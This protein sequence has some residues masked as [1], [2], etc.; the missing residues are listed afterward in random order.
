[1][2]R[3]RKQP[4]RQATLRIRA[5]TASAYGY[6]AVPSAKPNTG[7]DREWLSPQEQT[8]MPVHST[9]PCDTTAHTTQRRPGHNLCRGAFL[10]FQPI[11][12]SPNARATLRDTG[13]Q[14]PRF[15][16]PASLLISLPFSFLQS[17]VISKAL[18]LYLTAMALRCDLTNSRPVSNS[19]LQLQYTSIRT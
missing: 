6:A 15:N 9:T 2:G 7:R 1:M 4:R 12:P 13:N 19:G 14:S 8:G 5:H 10:T 18:R 11:I 16:G 3:S 17:S